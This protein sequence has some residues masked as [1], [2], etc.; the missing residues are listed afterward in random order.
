MA[1]VSVVAFDYDVNQRRG[2]VARCRREGGSEHEVSAHLDV[3]AL[4]LVPLKL[5]DQGLWTPDE[6]YWGEEDEPIEEWAKPIIARRRL[7]LDRE[8]A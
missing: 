1:P 6:H 4:G 3:A 2:L 7:A 8:M 5:E